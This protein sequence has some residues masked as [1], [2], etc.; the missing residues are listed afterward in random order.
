M[1]GSSSA[2][3]TVMTIG[4]GA[5]GSRIVPDYDA[6]SLMQFSSWVDQTIQQ[7]GNTGEQAITI[8]FSSSSSMYD[9]SKSA[10]FSHTDW[11]ANYWFWSAGGSSTTSQNQLSID[12]NSSKFNIRMAFDA[13]T[14]VQVKPGAWY[15]SSL[16]GAYQNTGALIR[17]TALL[18]A[19]YPSITLTMDA[20]SYAQ[21]QSAYNSSSGFGV[22]AFWASASTQKSIN[23]ASMQTAW[24]ASSN[25]VTMASQSIQPVVVGMLVAPLG[26]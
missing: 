14:T 23:T 24:N 9:F 5:S 21:A 1:L 12:T 19:M 16:M 15:D 13:L 3:P 25:S 22:G 20:A 17:P 2:L 6:S 4:T 7:H 10:Y 26:S 8:G 11:S 18:V